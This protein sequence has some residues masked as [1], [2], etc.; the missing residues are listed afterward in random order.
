MPAMRSPETAAAVIAEELDLAGQLIPYGPLRWDGSLPKVPTLHLDDFSAI[1]VLVGISGVEAYQ[2]RA[3]LRA[4]SGDLFAASTPQPDGYEQYCRSTLA[5]GDA[6]FVMAEMVEGE[7]DLAAALGRGGATSRLADRARGAGGLAIHPYMGIEAVWELASRLRDEADVAVQVLAPPPPV[8]WVANDKGRFARLVEL[9]LGS[10]W[11]VE[12]FS[13]IRTSRLAERLRELATRHEQVALKRLRCA[14]AMGNRVF[15]SAALVSSPSE[16]TERQVRSFLEETE[17]PGD[18]EVLAVA[19]EQASLSPS[20]QL[21]IPPFGGGSPRVDGV[22]EQILKGKRGVFVG[23]RPSTLPEA[24]SRRMIGASLRLAEALQR[25]GYVGRCSFDLLVVGERDAN[26]E[27][28]FTECNGRWGGTSTPMSLLD[29]LLPER[30]PYQ[31]QDF[32]DERLVGATLGDVLES[33]GTELFE[34]ADRRG[35]FI[36]YNTGPL[37]RHGKLSVIAL[38]SDHKEPQSALEEDLPHL[39]RL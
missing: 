16:E 22:Y 7:L 10:E 30:P 12:T 34:V 19:W 1:P 28:R 39:L 21:W 14:S 29:R 8:T 13:E 20:T 24:V 17:W 9:T 33:V 18:E 6:E 11:L 3:R 38:G 26:P 25:L 37:T 27:L 31:A 15:E 4:A 35:R 23:S 32:I 2:H 5:L 36:F